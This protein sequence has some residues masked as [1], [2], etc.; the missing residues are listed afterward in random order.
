MLLALLLWLK[1]VQSKD[2]V[3]IH[4]IIPT[5]LPIWIGVFFNLKNAAFK[6][7]DNESAKLVRDRKAGKSMHWLHQLAQNA[8]E[9]FTTVLST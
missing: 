1:L 4:I 9:E 6:K 3:L 8:S 2:P 7:I 5:L